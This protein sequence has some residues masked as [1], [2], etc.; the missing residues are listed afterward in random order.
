MC[1]ESTRKVSNCTVD[2]TGKCREIQRRSRRQRA[3]L[4]SNMC[5][6]LPR[7]TSPH[8]NR[9]KVRICA[10]STI[11]G[12]LWECET[13]FGLQSSLTCLTVFVLLITSIHLECKRVS[14]RKAPRSVSWRCTLRCARRV[15]S[16]PWRKDTTSR[17]TLLGRRCQ[18]W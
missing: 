2:H 15:E 14:K 5:P 9:T 3:R 10:G 12:E 13:F 11:R 6:Y 8:F 4:H 17:A 7:Q 1:K 16:L 18:P